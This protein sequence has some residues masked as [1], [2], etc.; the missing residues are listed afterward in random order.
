MHM[1]DALIT[2]A[3]GGTFW[4]VSGSLIAYSAHKVKAEREESMIPLMGVLSAFVFA[5]Q[6]INFSIPG[7]GSSG[8]LIGAMLL[9][10]FLG[11]Y[12]GFLAIASVLVIQCLFFADGGLMALGANIF[13]MGFFACFLAYPL[14]WKPWMARGFSRG[15][16]TAATTVAAVI[17]LVLGALGVVVET[18]TSGIS[19]LSFGTF[20]L[21]MVP[22]HAVIGLVEGAVTTAVS[23]FVLQARPDLIRLGKEAPAGGPRGVRVG[24]VT[25]GLLVSALAVG[26]FVS[27]FAS[28]RPEGLEW[29]LIQTTGHMPQAETKGVKGFL[30]R[31]Q[32]RLAPLPEYDFRGAPKATVNNPPSKTG[33][34]LS[35][36]LG[37]GLVLALAAGL[38][39]LMRR[40]GLKR[41]ARNAASPPEPSG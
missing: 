6:M 24:P 26:G 27:W 2:P 21:F 7:T 8:H 16:F 18:V 1:S 41:E 37:V 19:D 5:A 29:S 14:I 10:I 31:L 35:G 32:H 9:A 15:R 11:P 28:M 40:L 25:V 39:F 4:V 12:R 17:A 23:L 33:T 13:N 20:V 30:D 36:L 38:G 3:V 34:S 22:I